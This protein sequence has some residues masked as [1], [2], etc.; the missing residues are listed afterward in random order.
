MLASHDG[1]PLESELATQE[2]AVDCHRLRL[3]PR[4]NYAVFHL[5]LEGLIAT[6]TIGAERIF[7]FEE[8][9]IIGKIEDILAPV[10]D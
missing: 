8:S 1:G 3:L 2:L 10:I 6:W 5:S 7:G 9:E 4:V